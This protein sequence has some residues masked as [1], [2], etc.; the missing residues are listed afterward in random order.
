M[1]HTTLPRLPH[2]IL[3]GSIGEKRPVGRCVKGLSS[4]CASN[5]GASAKNIL[6]E[7]RTK[8]YI[9]PASP[10][11][12]I[13]FCKSYVRVTRVSCRSWPRGLASRDA[14]ILYKEVLI[15]QVIST[16]LEIQLSVYFSEWTLWDVFLFSKTPQT[17]KCIL[18]FW[19]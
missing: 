4:F 17:M 11:R 2:C 10:P 18:K 3:L 7:P 14:R 8:A 1:T 5:P 16:G 15:Q 19:K 6:L 9:S 12:V 13:E